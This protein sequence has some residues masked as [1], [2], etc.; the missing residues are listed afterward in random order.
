MLA[1]PSSSAASEPEPAV[2]ST[3]RIAGVI[4]DG[5]GK[6]VAG[7]T[8]TLLCS[9]L[10]KATST[11]TKA[12]GTYV[13]EGLPPGV[14][15]VRV[16]KGGRDVVQHLTLGEGERVSTTIALASPP[17]EEP[18]TS[19][20]AKKSKGRV[21]AKTVDPMGLLDPSASTSRST[22]RAAR[23]RDAAG[24]AGGVPGGV[25]GGTLGGRSAGVAALRVPVEPANTE[26]Y[27]H[28]RENDFVAV[29]DAPL[30]TFSADVD[31]ASYSNVRRFLSQGQRPPIDAVRVEELVNYFE[32]DY[33]TPPDDRPVT[34]NW[35][36]GPCPWNEDHQLVRIGLQTKPIADAEV[37]P[38]N[39]VFLVD[40]SGSMQSPDK[41]PLLVRSMGLLVDQLRE[42]DMVSLV[43]Y[44]GASGLVLPPTS[45]AYRDRIRDALAEL[46]PGGSTN[47][48]AG[49][50]LAYQQ[51]RNAFIEGGINRVILATDGDFNVG[52]TSDGDLVRL[53]EQERES[54]VFLS[55]LGFGQG[56]LQDAKMEQ[57]ADE[58]N[59]NYAYIDDLHEGRKV[60]VQQAGA[61]LVTVAKDV[62]LQ[63]EFNPA[64]VAEYRQVGY[65]NRRLRDE[66]FND[67]T[68]DAGEMGAGHSVTVLYEIV[69]ASGGEG[70]GTA[71]RRV[72]ALKY[73][74]ERTTT[75]AAAS[76]EL[77]TV[78]VRFKRPQG[79]KSRLM[80]VAVRGTPSTLA[81]TSD[82]F[83]FA[84]AVAELG[85]ILRDS[86]HK[87]SAT[88]ESVAMLARK[89]QGKDPHGHR[90]G[91]LELVEQARAVGY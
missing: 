19:K 54:G 55:V 23:K 16:R 87:G 44:A 39:L 35:E 28:I 88:L 37:P 25:V 13:F 41:L 71:P 70:G 12:D 36:V 80:S 56:N 2:A 76:D 84:A 21:A 15:S 91:L 29:S 45:G 90:K 48:A 31:T 22:S 68:K 17:K 82:D 34:V 27:A 6:P 67:D 1:S 8:V 3:G 69:P 63:V 5:A 18:A 64:L 33:V 38:R 11:K 57:L 86:E 40:V 85:M 79:S 42:Q 46:T 59:G 89:A 24:V 65:E 52:T 20:P 78:K 7:A 58:G 77:M 53:I 73:Q 32:Y 75:A 61:T 10:T 47:G 72:D 49:I 30:S 51:A 66:D 60:L 83:R 81:K 14:Y 26:G 50:R 4:H 62:K 9:C 74:G 43:V